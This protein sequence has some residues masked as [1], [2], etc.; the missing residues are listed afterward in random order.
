MVVKEIPY[1]TNVIW[2]GSVWRWRGGHP[3]INWAYAFMIPSEHF[4][5]FVSANNNFVVFDFNLI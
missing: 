3:A 1:Y 5:L 2:I 4:W